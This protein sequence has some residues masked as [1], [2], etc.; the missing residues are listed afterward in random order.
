MNQVNRCGDSALHAAACARQ[1][2]TCAHL[3]RL[4]AR[5]LTRNKN[6]RD[7]EAAARDLGFHDLADWVAGTRLG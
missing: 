2:P 7:A 5:K 6:G 1:L 4:G 3:L